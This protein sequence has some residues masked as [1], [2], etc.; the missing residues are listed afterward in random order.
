MWARGS[1]G[2]SQEAP[3]TSDPRLLPHTLQVNKPGSPGQLEG[4]HSRDARFTALGR[5]EEWCLWEM[6][7]NCKHPASTV[8]S[9][10][11]QKSYCRVALTLLTSHR[12]PQPRTPQPRTP[13]ATLCGLAATAASMGKLDE[14]EPKLASP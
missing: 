13:T 11:P 4:N 2:L 5:P 9:V 12:P 3:A 1:E 10:L 6:L 8:F 7:E 14:G